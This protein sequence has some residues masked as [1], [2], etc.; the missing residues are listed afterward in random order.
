MN[1]FDVVPQRRPYPPTM[2]PPE[3]D[4]SL[5]ADAPP[6]RSGS[7]ALIPPLE[8]SSGFPG[9]VPGRRSVESK[10]AKMK[11]DGSQQIEQRQDQTRV[12]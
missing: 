9:V 6:P 7:T 1:P 4:P 3:S 8:P 2:T 10:V 5:R 11:Q 12:S